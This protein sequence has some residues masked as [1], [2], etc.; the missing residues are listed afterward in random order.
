VQITGSVPAKKENVF[1]DFVPRERMAV[2]GARANVL[3]L[4]PEQR[5]QCGCLGRPEHSARQARAPLSWSFAA[6]T[7]SRASV[8]LTQAAEFAGGGLG[9]EHVTSLDRALEAATRRALDARHMF[10]RVAWVSAS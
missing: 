4:C 7:S 9:A 1:C 10:V 3:A 5:C 8:D 2:P 6:M